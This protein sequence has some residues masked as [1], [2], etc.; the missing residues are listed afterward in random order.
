MCPKC[1]REM[2]LRTARK[3]GNE[4]E[5]FGLPK[6][7]STMFPNSD[8]SFREKEVRVQRVSGVQADDAV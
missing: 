8:V 1:E 4:G 6:P 5:Q 2:A 7:A 3:G